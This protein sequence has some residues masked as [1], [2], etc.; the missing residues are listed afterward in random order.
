MTWLCELLNAHLRIWRNALTKELKFTSQPSVRSSYNFDVP[1]TCS[2][3]GPRLVLFFILFTPGKRLKAD[4]QFDYDWALD[5][6]MLRTVESPAMEA[7]RIATTSLVMTSCFFNINNVLSTC[8]IASYI[9]WWKF[10]QGVLSNMSEWYIAR[11]CAR[12]ER[13]TQ[14]KS[15]TFQYSRK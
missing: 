4:Y 5:A 15:K 6:P 1:K 8:L 10:V 7:S 2:V 13:Q 3:H 9:V 11:S 12:A 14:M